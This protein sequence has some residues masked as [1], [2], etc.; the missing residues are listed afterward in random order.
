MS[1]TLEEA[2]RELRAGRLRLTRPDGELIE[3]APEADDSFDWGP[4]YL[5]PPFPAP[6]LTG[7]RVPPENIRLA[8]PFPMKPIVID[9][10]D[11][12]PE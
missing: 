9:E 5:D 1:I 7:T 10:D 6:A 8:N 4:P 11:L 2:V 3:L 12:A